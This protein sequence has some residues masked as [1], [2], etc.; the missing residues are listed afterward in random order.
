MAPFLPLDL[1]GMGGVS[2]W[3]FLVVSTYLKS[4]LKNYVP[5]DFKICFKLNLDWLKFCFRKEEIRSLFFPSFND[6]SLKELKFQQPKYKW[7][8][9]LN[10]K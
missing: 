9:P 4:N 10:Q 7:T 1:Q 5:C 3:V 6:N 2:L 8:S